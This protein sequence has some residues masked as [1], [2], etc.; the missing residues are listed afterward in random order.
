MAG[1]KMEPSRSV[2]KI[3]LPLLLLALCKEHF[4]HYTTRRIKA[5]GWHIKTQANLLCDVKHCVE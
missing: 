3:F 1:K 4:Q 2:G 5:P